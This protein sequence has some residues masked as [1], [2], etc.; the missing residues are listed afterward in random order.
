MLHMIGMIVQVK[1]CTNVMTSNVSKHVIIYI[2]VLYTEPTL[3]MLLG[4]EIITYF[5]KNKVSECDRL[6]IAE[7]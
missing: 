2:A 3:V 1:F 7:F 4:G 6:N 5:L